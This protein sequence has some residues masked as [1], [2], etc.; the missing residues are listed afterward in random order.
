[1]EPNGVIREFYDLYGQEWGPKFWQTLDDLAQEL[2]QLL[3]I[4]RAENGDAPASSVEGLTIYL[5]RATYDLNDLW[6]TIRRDLQQRGHI[7]LPEQPLPLIGPELETQ[8][9]ANLARSHL[10]LH[11]LGETYGVVPEAAER[12][13]QEI[14]NLLAAQ[15]SRAAGLPR[16]I[17]APPGAAPNDARQRAFLHSLRNDSDQLAGAELLE[18]PIEELR[19]VLLDRLTQLQQPREPQAASG[20]HSIKVWLMTLMEHL[21]TLVYANLDVDEWTIY[22][23]WAIYRPTCPDRPFSPT[24]G[25]RDMI[26]DGELNLLMITW[27]GRFVALSASSVALLLLGLWLWWLYHQLRH[28]PRVIVFILGVIVLMLAWPVYRLDIVHA[29][30]TIFGKTILL[31]TTQIYIWSMVT[32]LLAGLLLWGL[33]DMLRAR[34]RAIFAGVMVMLM[35]GR[36]YTTGEPFNLANYIAIAIASLVLALALWGLFQICLWIF[37]KLFRRGQFIEQPG[38]SITGQARPRPPSGRRLD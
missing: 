26:R 17:W 13:A 3:K 28:R 21:C 30:L 16:L 37:R 22:R 27:P 9:A 14:E 11:L 8:V 29:P 18:T 32:G 7:V 33:Y 1:V 12:S 4:M 10:A 38:H 20:D 23:Q 36:H 31:P 2:C 19:T 5:G 35:I 25:V 6:E 34:R 15:R 24:P